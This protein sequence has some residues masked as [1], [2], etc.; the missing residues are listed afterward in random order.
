MGGKAAGALI[1]HLVNVSTD[2]SRPVERVVPVSG[3][4]LHVRLAGPGPCRIRALVADEDLLC[5]VENGMADISLPE[6]NEYEVV[7]IE[8]VS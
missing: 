8:R 1:V 5:H 2:L 4:T 3:G 6:L 7:V